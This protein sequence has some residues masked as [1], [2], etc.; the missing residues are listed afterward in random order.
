MHGFRDK[1][2]NALKA[3]SH[4]SEGQFVCAHL[5]GGDVGT[6]ALSAWAPVHVLQHFAL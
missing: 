1:K 2:Q 5:A 6:E 4:A 3:S